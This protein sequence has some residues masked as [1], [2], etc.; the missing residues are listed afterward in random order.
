MIMRSQYDAFAGKD[1]VDTSQFSVNPFQRVEIIIGS[2]SSS[3]ALDR[4]V[5]EFFPQLEGTGF[6]VEQADYPVLCS[7]VVPSSSVGT[8]LILRQGDIVEASFKGL[9]ISHP[10]LL[11]ALPENRP[12]KLSLILFKNGTKYYNQLSD[13]QVA[14]G[15][16]IRTVSLTATLN[17]TRIYV[18]PGVRA[19]TG[20][21]F[22]IRGAAS[23]TGATATFVDSSGNSI[24]NAPPVS[25]QIGSA[26]VSYG[27]AGNSPASEIVPD[28]T[29]GFRIKFGKLVVPSGAAELALTINGTTFTITTG[30][31]GIWS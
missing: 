21:Q 30:Y 8:A 15:I 31:A 13:P 4:T 2:G 12:Y 28:P 6:L 10:R 27:D 7:L 22:S 5:P 25:Q 11:G 9:Y 18:P 29:G 19:L 3:A 24:L 26:I 17:D 20:L 14:Y 23:V 16:S 1:N